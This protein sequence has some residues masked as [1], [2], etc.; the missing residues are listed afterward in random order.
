M[1]RE[2][3][4]S[5]LA[6]VDS[7][8]SV[9]LCRL[10]ETRGSTPQKAGAAMLVFADGSQAGTLGGG[11]VEAEVKR[12]ALDAINTRRAAIETFQLNSDY[13]WD[14]GLICGGRMK[15]LID[16]LAHADSVEYCQRLSERI[17]NGEGVIEAIS[18]EAPAAIS[19]D[20]AHEPIAM[21]GEPSPALQAARDQLPDLTARPSPSAAGGVAF[22]PSLPREMLVIVGA[23]H[24]GQ[25]VAKLAVD[26]DFRVTV[27]DD[28][29]EF[30][31]TERFPHAEARITGTFKEVLP[32]VSITP[33]TFC[34]IVTRGHNHDEEALF[35]LV[36]RGARYVGMIGSKRKIR[37]IFDDLLSEGVRP[38]ALAKVHAP[39]GLAIG[40]QTVAEIAISI[41]AQ[42]IQ[43]RNNRV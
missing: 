5:M 29:A 43:E 1:I 26:L 35:H 32:N 28:R 22:L 3:L 8:R 9:A 31:T 12:K 37:L 18:L 17:L 42:L 20:A 11:C 2:L 24:V 4:P 7:G 36:D 10:V 25:A 23:G 33:D 39:V 14:D 30:V 15:V 27:I 16:P 34:L 21:M 41:A 6:A 19:F 38:E 40:S 13:G